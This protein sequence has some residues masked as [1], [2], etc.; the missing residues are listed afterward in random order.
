MADAPQHAPVPENL[1][2]PAAARPLPGLRGWFALYL[3]WMGGLALLARAM[4]QQYEDGADAS[5]GLWLLAL[6]CFYLSLCNIFLPMP[7]TWI[8]LL[9]GSDEMA[10]IRDPLLRIA[11]VGVCGA[12]ATTMANLNEYHVLG[13]F[14]RARLGDRVRR[15]RAYR[16]SARW[17]DVSPFRVLMLV[18]FVPIPVDVVRWI[19]ILRRYPRPR[20]A[21]AYFLGRALRYAL[22][23]GLSIALRL[24]TVQIIIIQAVLA[25]ALAAR[26][27]VVA[28]RGIRAAPHD[29]PHADWPQ[30]NAIEE[31]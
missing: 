4:F 20:Y 31:S 7:T 29:S 21:G 14:F 8:V 17:F 9:A 16:W 11:L 19:A 30:R 6:T 27:I 5:R 22:L 25:L 3:L 10:L 1:D 28:L 23:S 24:T 12:L 26:V 18:S 2:P 13:Y 15:T